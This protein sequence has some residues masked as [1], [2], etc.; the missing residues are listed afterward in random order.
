MKRI[1]FHLPS[2][3]ALP[4]VALG[5]LCG[6]PSAKAASITVD[7]FSFEQDFGTDATTNWVSETLWGRF[8]FSDPP[9]PHGA[10][11]AVASANNQELYQIL[12]THT[13]APGDDFT[14]RVDVGNP[15][16]T[17]KPFFNLTVYS[18]NGPNGF[19]FLG[20]FALPTAPAAGTWETLVA[21]VQ[22]APDNW[23]IGGKL[24]L[25]LFSGAGAGGVAVDNVR[26]DLIPEPATA[27]C[28]MLGLGIFGILRS[29][30]RR[31]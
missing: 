15:G 1:L 13:I 27:A 8:E 20:G 2:S 7:N 24:Q 10:F 14:I 5:L 11:G 12:D 21:N 16:G 28:F 6:S 18:V 9:P 22:I 25:S 3:L 29:R 4:L 23:G 31:L 19:V 30:S 26:V 17:F